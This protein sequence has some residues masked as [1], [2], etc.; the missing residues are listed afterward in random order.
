MVLP[1][2][3]DPGAHNLF[4]DQYA[5][6]FQF[7]ISGPI[8]YRT[9]PALLSTPC[10]YRAKSTDVVENYFSYVR[11]I[12]GTPTLHVFLK[13]LPNILRTF[14]IC[15]LP[16]KKFHCVTQ[17][18]NI[19]NHDDLDSS[20]LVQKYDPITKQAYTEIKAKTTQQAAPLQAFTARLCNKLPQNPLGSMS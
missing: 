11:V 13:L 7:S 17:A 1:P 8:R 4:F 12:C 3:D 15:V 2:N 10:N 6:T 18:S 19:Y 16:D 20:L 5:S 14:Y 9:D